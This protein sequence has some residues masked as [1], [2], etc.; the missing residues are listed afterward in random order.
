MSWSL[1]LLTNF[2][3]NVICNTYTS[4]VTVLLGSCQHPKDNKC[5]STSTPSWSQH[6]KHTLCWS[7]STSAYHAGDQ[8]SASHAGIHQTSNQ[9]PMP[10]K[11][12]Y[13]LVTSNAAFFSRAVK[14]QSISRSL[15]VLAI[16][17][18]QSEKAS[19]DRAPCRSCQ[20]KGTWM[21]KAHGDFQMAT[22]TFRWG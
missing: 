20:R 5:W 14:H 1:Q 19:R 18:V 22:V 16:L 15:S 6:A 17:A 21:F 8:H 4:F 10:V 7:T 3:R 9:H 12:Y 2:K 13:M 11:T